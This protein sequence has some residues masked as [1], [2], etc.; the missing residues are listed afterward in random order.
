M[1][2]KMKP[3]NFEGSKL[4]RIVKKANVKSTCISLRGLGQNFNPKFGLILVMYTSLG[5]TIQR[6]SIF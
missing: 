4:L 5:F 6:W 2:Y 3:C 1:L